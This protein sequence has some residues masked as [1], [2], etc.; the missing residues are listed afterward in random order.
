V[1]ERAEIPAVGGPV[2]GRSLSVLLDDDGFPPLT[3][4]ESWL[5]TTYGSELWDADTAGVYELEPVA[6][7]GPPFVYRW[8]PNRR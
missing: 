1:W 2:D 4:D 6:G 5:W 8:V 7:G 3:L